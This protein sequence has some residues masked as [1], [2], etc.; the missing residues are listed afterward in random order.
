MIGS[1]DRFYLDT[2]TIIAILE[3]QSPATIPQEAFLRSI[4]NGECFCISSEIALSECIVKPLRDG[5]ESLAARFVEFIDTQLS[6]MPVVIDRAALVAAARMRATVN[7][8]LPDALH[9][10]CAHIADCTVF[11]S[12][13]KGVKLP[14]SMRRLAFDE[15]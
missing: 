12:A 13:D 9:V 7:V 11:I 4:A 5:K 14:A 8:K 15:L 3:R 1:D 2:N 6:A 10:A